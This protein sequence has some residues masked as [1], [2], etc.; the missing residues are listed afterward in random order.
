[1]YGRILLDV[2]FPQYTFLNP[3]R[4]LLNKKSHQEARP[5][6]FKKFCILFIEGLLCLVVP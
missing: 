1:M 5:L 4:G 6:G 2:K 3:Q